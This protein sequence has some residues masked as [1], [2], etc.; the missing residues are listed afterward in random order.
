MGVKS[1][2]FCLR[3]IVYLFTASAYSLG[4]NFLS[5]G[6]IGQ[7]GISHR[8]WYHVKIIDGTYK[9]NLLSVSSYTREGYL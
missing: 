4:I 8:Y 5:L 1:I 3:I 2:Y 6:R 9:N 7:V